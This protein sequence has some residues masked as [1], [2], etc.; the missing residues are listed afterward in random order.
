[1]KTILTERLRNRTLADAYEGFFG[2]KPVMHD[3]RGRFIEK[4]GYYIMT[5]Y[6]PAYAL[7]NP[8]NKMP[9]YEDMGKVRAKLEEIGALPPLAD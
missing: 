1:M 8:K 7:R 5:T 4:N 3:V 9:I 6:H 2:D